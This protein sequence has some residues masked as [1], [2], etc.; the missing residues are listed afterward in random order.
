M[1][2]DGHVRALLSQA[3]LQ[4]STAAQIWREYPGW[5]GGKVK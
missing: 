4:K 5:R 2:Q 3:A 1:G